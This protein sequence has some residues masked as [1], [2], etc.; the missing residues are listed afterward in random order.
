MDIKVIA[1]GSSGNCYRVSDGETSLLLDAGIPFKRIQAGCGFRTSEIHGCLVTH[2]HGDH[3]KAI[4]KLLERGMRV[5]GPM[6][7]AA[8]YPG[9]QILPAL[10]EYALGTLGILPFHVEHD[11]ECYGY[12][13]TSMATREKLLYITDTAYIRYTFR[14]L[15]HLMVEAN[16]GQEIIMDNAMHGKVPLFLAERVVRSH[17]SI[18]TLLGLLKAND[19]KEVRQIYL[20]HL[21]DGNSNAEDFKRQAQRETGA[22]V[23]VF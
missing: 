23:Y 16:Y 5:Y 8:L 7:L 13:V 22:E 10:K 21:S 14:G 3:A 19:M 9:V 1:S 6:E 18:E 2:R 4:P 11:V 20:L 17:M 12:Q 15:T